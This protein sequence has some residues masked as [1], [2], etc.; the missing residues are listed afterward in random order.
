MFQRKILQFLFDDWLCATY[1]KFF[2]DSTRKME[3]NEPR[4]RF[5]LLTEDELR[6]FID[7]ADSKNTKSSIKYVE[8]IVQQYCS[9][10][11]TTLEIVDHMNAV[12]NDE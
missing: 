11:N 9:V 3:D 4:P 5:D 7:S 6:D 8:R 2:D 12:L 10:R 1:V